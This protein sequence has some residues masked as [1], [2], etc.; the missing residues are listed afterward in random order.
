MLEDSSVDSKVKLV[1]AVFEQVRLS[2][3]KRITWSFAEAIAFLKCHA[4]ES[5]RALFK[6]AIALFWRCGVWKVR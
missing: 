6:D 2:M 5:Y 1:K 4:G 3:P